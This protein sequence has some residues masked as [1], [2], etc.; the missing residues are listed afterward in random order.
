MLRQTVIDAGVKGSSWKKYMWKGLYHMTGNRQL[1]WTNWKMRVLKIKNSFW[2]ISRYHASKFN[3]FS[4]LLY[5]HHH[6]FK[7]SKDEMYTTTFL[8]SKLKPH[9]LPCA[10][11]CLNLDN[12]MGK[13]VVSL[14][15]ECL[16]LWASFYARTYERQPIFQYRFPSSCVRSSSCWF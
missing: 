9:F 16:F 6:I 14:S 4:N 2:K 15:N 7:W 12:S 3:V 5:T 10:K 13:T 11:L 8:V 1:N